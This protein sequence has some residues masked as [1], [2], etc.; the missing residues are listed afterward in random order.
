MLRIEGQAQENTRQYEREVETRF[1]DQER[2][3]AKEKRHVVQQ[4]E[5]RQQLAVEE[6]YRKATVQ[7]REEAA[8]RQSRMEGAQGIGMVRIPLA[9]E[10]FSNTV[11][12]GIQCGT[13]S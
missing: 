4:A 10:I 7:M 11:W 6:A 3:A 9:D 12:V 2:Q 8:H 5:H 13:S 1:K